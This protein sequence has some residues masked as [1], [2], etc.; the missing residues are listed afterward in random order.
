MARKAEYGRGHTAFL[1]YVHFIIDDPNYAGMPDVHMDNGDIQW[2]A[3]SNRQG[4]K[5]KD[6][7]H[8]RRDWWRKKAIEIGIDP[9]SAQWISTTA[10][11]IHPTRSEE[12]RV[13]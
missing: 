12:R 9:T 8:R 1:D 11:A 2:E 13:G 5:F 4:G 10:K 7:H 3:P 6:T